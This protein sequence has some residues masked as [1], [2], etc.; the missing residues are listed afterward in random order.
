MQCNIWLINITGPFFTAAFVAAFWRL[1]GNG[2]KEHETA[3]F[4]SRCYGMTKKVKH[5]QLRVVLCIL[6]I[7][8]SSGSVYYACQTVAAHPATFKSHAQ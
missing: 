8:V 3:F 4:W 5:R 1:L 7:S 2:R 6:P